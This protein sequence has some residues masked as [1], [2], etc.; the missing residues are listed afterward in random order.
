MKPRFEYPKQIGGVSIQ[1]YAWLAV[2]VLGLLPLGYSV[3]GYLFFGTP[4]F[5]EYV[6]SS[7]AWGLLVPVYVFFV[8]AG[9][10][11][12]LIASL[13][14]IFRIGDFELISRSAIFLAIVMLLTGF[15]AIAIDLGRLD[16][17][18][19]PFLVSQNFSSPMMW[20]MLLYVL[21]LV[22]VI[23][24]FWLLNR[25]DLSVKA[26]SSSGIKSLFYTVLTL[27]YRSLS[28]ESEE[29]DHRIARMIGVGAL[30]LAVA[31]PSNLGALFGVLKARP[32]LFGAY[33]PI[34]FVLTALVS[35]AAVLLLTTILTQRVTR[36]SVSQESRG[37]FTSLGRIMGLLLVIYLLFIS[38]KTMTSLF[39]QIPHEADALALLVSGP[40]MLQFWGLEVIV[41]GIAPLLLLIYPRTGKSL[42]GILAAASLVLIGMFFVRYDLIIAGQVV[43][44]LEGSQ[45]LYI[46]SQM[47]ITLLVSLIALAALVYSIG[48]KI[49]SLSGETTAVQHH[50]TTAQHE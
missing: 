14:H 30:A 22:V 21:Y 2:L 50:Q 7:V 40:M 33:M 19:I 27:G 45:S 10:G 35:G 24:E 18:Y 15:T 26:R 9:S 1:F 3:G 6:S 39:S 41:G 17:A 46:P 25:I 44:A 49:F 28:E 20:M 13:G 48:G 23:V 42:W 5:A 36:Q 47:E 34:F 43:T 37:V 38:W 12:C 8:L 16:R 11:L 32:L 29:R 31:A 4:I